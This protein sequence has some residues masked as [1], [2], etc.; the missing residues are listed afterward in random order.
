MHTDTI[1]SESPTSQSTSLAGYESCYNFVLFVLFSW[2]SKLFPRRYAFLG[3]VSY[4]QGGPHFCRNYCNPL[5]SSYSYY[6]R[7]S[8]ADVARVEK[9]T[10]VCTEKKEDTVPTPK[11]GVESKLGNWKDPDEMDKELDKKF[12]GCMKGE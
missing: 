5:P 12:T 7:T 4:S 9:Q 3:L 11:E 6:A 1:V 8:P 10:F 2:P